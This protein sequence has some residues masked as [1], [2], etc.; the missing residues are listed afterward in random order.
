MSPTTCPL[1]NST[2]AFGVTAF[3]YFFPLLALFYPLKMLAL[4]FA[5]VAV[6]LVRMSY[7]L[8]LHKHGDMLYEGVVETIRAHLTGRAESLRGVPD[9]TLLQRVKEVWEAHG[10]EMSLVRDILMYMDKTFVPT[11]P[12]RKVIWDQGL[13]LFRG[14][15]LGHSGLRGRVT[16]QLVSAFAGARAGVAL[17][18]SLLSSILT[19]LVDLG[20]GTLGVY[21]EE[22][23]APFLEEAASAL[24]VKSHAFLTAH[25][26]PEYLLWAEGAMESEKAALA[27]CGHPTTLPK[28]SALLEKTLVADHAV[29]LVELPGSGLRE[30]LERGDAEARSHVARLHKLFTLCKAPVQ[31]LDRGGAG[32]AA[33]A[34]PDQAVGATGSSSSSSSSSSGGKLRTLPPLGIMRESFKSFVLHCGR[35]LLAESKDASAYVQQLVLLRRRHADGLVEHFLGGDKDFL[36]ALKEAMETLLNAPGDTRPPEYLCVF[37]DEMFR[38]GFREKSEGEVDE[39]M[40]QVVV[41]FRFLHNKDEFEERYKCMLQRRLLG[42]KVISDDYEK[43]MISLLKTECGF[44]FT[45]KLEGMFNDLR[46]SSE[47]MDKFRA[48]GLGKGEA[49]SSSATTTTPAT[50][51]SSN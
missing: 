4:S 47:V 31:W 14:C 36:R 9:D 24:G 13:S 10:R 11:N 29:A 15:V 12:S 2:G 34:S 19:M 16:A 3:Y 44:Q 6:V 32:A 39:C 18:G 46:V 42:G 49:A 5:A 43:L 33:A 27:R 20:S 7:Q 23:E 26:C 25:S 35:A 30:L 17:D 28:L 40:S 21:A 8:V 45:S 37:L 1:R 41:L 22:F 38:G 50:I 51:S 48:S